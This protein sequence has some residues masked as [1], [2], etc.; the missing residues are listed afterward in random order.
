MTVKSPIRVLV[1]ASTWWW[2]EALL[3]VLERS[4]AR[5]DPRAAGGL[6][7]AR[8]RM[9]EHEVAIVDLDDGDG[10]VTLADARERNLATIALSSSATLEQ[11]NAALSLGASYVVKSELDPD[12]LRHLVTMSASGDALLVRA[13]NRFLSNL[14]VGP[15]RDRYNLTPREAEVLTHLA[16]GRTNAEIAA[17]MH[18]AP[19]SVKKLVSRCL[20]R[21]GVRNRVEAALVARREGLVAPSEALVHGTDVQG[22]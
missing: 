11:V 10:L 19:S 13:S 12:R 8:R 14:A 2:R 6:T 16:R 18:L 15:P 4:D 20:T 1:V 9:A 3:R 7:A 17:A 21:L 22:R 5:F